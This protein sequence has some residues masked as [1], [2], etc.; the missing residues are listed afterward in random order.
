[1][2]TT[3]AGTLA[4]SDVNA[5]V[6]L[7][8]KYATGRARDQALPPAARATRRC[9]TSPSSG[10]RT[11]PRPRSPTGR[12]LPAG[13]GRSNFLRSVSAQ[14]FNSDPGLGRAVAQESAG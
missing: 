6:D 14:W 12:G 4:G 3:M 9:R 11:I 10:R 7:I 1:M 5:A 8:S 13:E 2:I